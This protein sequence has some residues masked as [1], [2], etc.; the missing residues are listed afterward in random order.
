MVKK[1]ETM[2]RRRGIVKWVLLSVLLLL[3]LGYWHSR[4]NDN[5]HTVTIGE[6]YRSAQLDPDELSRYIERYGIRSVL[7]LRGCLKDALWYQEELEV[8]AEHHVEHY[9]LG[10]SAS[11][12][13]T[14]EDI[15]Q[16]IGIFAQA[17]RPILI[18]CLAGADRSGLVA[19]MW[20]VLVDGEEKRVA[21]RQLSIWYGH[22]PLGDTSVL[23][24]FFDDWTPPVKGISEMTAP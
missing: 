15:R 19:A 20:K 4:E 12:A 8:C 7:N 22:V 24:C 14:D 6:A 11:R 5:F 21:K 2:K 9:D 10:L 17:P 13:P 23:D 16:L 18:H 1:G 3:L